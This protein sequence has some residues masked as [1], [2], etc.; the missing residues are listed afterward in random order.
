[1]SK[2]ERKFSQ[3]ALPFRSQLGN[4]QGI[5]K[6]RSKYLFEAAAIDT[7]LTHS[8]SKQP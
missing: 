7:S 8:A 2:T 6:T 5:G 1:M 3:E 4:P